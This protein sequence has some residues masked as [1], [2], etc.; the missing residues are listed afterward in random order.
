MG[1]NKNIIDFDFTTSTMQSTVF[2][3]NIEI[4]YLLEGI[5]EVTVEA[6][7]YQLEKG[8]I[9]LINAN[10]KHSLKAKSEKVFAARFQINYA[11][12]VEHL[13]TNQILF[14]C[15]TTVDKNEAYDVLRNIF[16]RI[17]N[18]YFEKSGAGAL[19][20]N[21]LYYEALYVL[22]SYFTI[23]ATDARLKLIGLHDGTRVFEI[24]NYVQANYLQQLS[25]NDLAK[26]LYLS[27]AYL[28]KYIKK[29][30]GVSFVE[31]LN[32]VRLFH[33]VDELLYTDK[34]IINIALDNGFPT[35]ASFNKAF[36]NSY[37]LT[38]S[39][40]RAKERKE[41]KL[42]EMRTEESE[43][44]IQ[45]MWQEYLDEKEVAERF[46]TTKQTDVYEVDARQTIELKRPW[47][48]VINIGDLASLLRSDV[49]AHILIMQ[50][51]LGF[52]HVRLWNIFMASMY[53][54]NGANGKRY[55]FSKL[56]RVLDFLTEHQLH[57]FIELA[58]KPM[59]LISTPD[60]FL[61][62]AEND[63]IF[64]SLEDYEAALQ[65]LVSRL[66]NHYGLEEVEN[67]YFELW[68]DPRMHIE[69]E[70]GWYFSCFDAGYHA[71]KRIS[72]KIKVG[73]AGFIL[74]Y[75]N[76]KYRDSISIWK[77]R[78][79]WPDFLS[80][81]GYR[82]FTVEQDGMLFGRKSL[83]GSFIQN[84]VKLLRNVLSEEQ[85]EIPE[86]Y[87]T[88]WN[89]TISNRNC[90]NDSCAQGAYVMKNCIDAVGEIDLMAY[91]HGTDLY[92]EYFDT[93][94]ILNGDC[95][96]LTKEGIKKPSFYAFQFLRSL[97]PQLLGKNEYAILTANGRGGYT[98]ACH[99]SKKLTYRYAVKEEN[100][101]TIAE[102]N[103]LYEDLEP[104]ELKFA[105]AH[106]EN[107]E[108]L[109]KIGYINQ[110]S[111][112]VQDLWKEMGMVSNLSHGEIDYL[113]RSSMPQVEMKRIHVTDGTLRMETSLQAHEIRVINID[114][115]FQRN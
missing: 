11:M 70:E 39:A 19:Y 44:A 4:L 47:G 65:E 20:L 56:D 80:V 75:E 7:A 51:E 41:V 92:S 63:I 111:G 115:Y 98:I 35:T 103:R 50:K 52:S 73:G 55:N 31:Y 107:G 48:K 38:P 54:P 45:K 33:A 88:E 58:F 22:T 69:A 64:Q 1:I 112:S 27:T 74:G 21:S 95:G 17:L 36:K 86:V 72:P 10:K 57:P 62:D 108:Y 16:D 60:V 100:E 8:D 78:S 109:I 32:N 77:N 12:L 84:Q 3:Q 40:Y 30:F 91:W 43:E 71:L 106:V 9:L 46:I 99:N 105:I 97:Q 102:Q 53:N 85:F 96:L 49:Q 67:W 2:H 113:K 59:Q 110:N 90:L 42:V 26:K 81:Y 29:Y 68:R 6:E 24:Q 34:R 25:L 5:I 37:Q 101:I 66:V 87:V 104:V 79:I 76:H 83:D 89:F 23:K 28:S 14:W 15:N 18:R 13:G 82:Y 93:E 94:A 114:Y 61:V